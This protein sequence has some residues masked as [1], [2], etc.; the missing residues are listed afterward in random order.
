MIHVHLNEC[1]ST[2]DVLK[3]QLRMSTSSE[4]IL[5]SCEKQLKGRGRG[6]HIWTAMNGTLCFSISLSAHQKQSFTALEISVLIARFFGQKGSHLTL[7]WPNDLFNSLG[8]KCGGILIQNSG[9]IMMCGIG[10]NLF[11]DSDEF[12]GVFQSYFALEKKIWAHELA[13]FIS[14]NRYQKTEALKADWT[15]RCEHLQEEIEIIE[16]GETTRGIFMGLGEDGEA[17]VRTEKE[18]EHLYNGRLRIISR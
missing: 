12:G 14:H 11:S 7:K 15:D 5:V 18:I 13:E 4:T 6:N 3:E 2:Q 16:S 10:V 17:L 8:K 1:N 9:D